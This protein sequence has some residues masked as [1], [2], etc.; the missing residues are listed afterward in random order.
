LRFPKALSLLAALA[1]A[2]SLSAATF[3]VPPDRDLV[4]RADAIVI[5]SP[6]TSYSRLNTAG[7]IET[8]TPFSV[9]EIV[10]GVDVP[11]VLDIVE[12]GGTYGDRTSVIGGVPR[13]VEGQRQ[14]LMVKRTAPDRWAVEELVLGK[15]T[16]AVDTRGRELLVRDSDEI[17]GWDSNLQPHH[18]PLRAAASFLQFVRDEAR[19]IP[20]RQNYFL[21]DPAPFRPAVSSTS[22]PSTIEP[23]ATFTATSYTMTV[24][25]SLG[26]RWNV[27]P[28]AV[29]FFTGT[30]TEPGAPGGGVTAVQ[31]AFAS[32]D[33]DCPSNVNYVYGGT[34]NGTHTSGIRAADGANTV[35]FE[36]D[37]S[38]LGIAPFTCSGSSYSG[39]LG[40]GG[41]TAA[42]GNNVVSGETFVTTQEGDVE[43]NRGIANCTLLFSNGD[44]NSAVTHEVGHTLGFRHSDQNRASNGACTADLECSNQ[45]IMRSFIPNGL[46]G[47]LQAWDQHA[48]QSVYPGGSCGTPG[49][50]AKRGDLDGSGR[51]DILWRDT[52]SGANT[53]WN[54]S[55]S[56]LLSAPAAPSMSTG[57]SLAGTGDFNADSRADLLWRNLN[58]GAAVI[59]LM[60]GQV[61]TGTINLP[62]IS[63]AYS[64]AGVG[65]FNGDG[66]ADILWRNTQ[67]A[68]TSIW[69][70]TPTGWS[71][72]GASLSA[73]PL[74]YRV[75]SVAD[76][77][78]DGKADIVWRNTNTGEVYTWLLN[79]GTVIGGSFLGTVSLSYALL[80]TG[81]FNGDGTF[82]LLWRNLSSGDTSVW[83]LSNGAFGGQGASLGTVPPPWNIVG[84]GDFNGDGRYDL[85][86]HNS[87]T[88]QNSIWFI[89]A[90]GRSG[91]VDLP[92]T[93]SSLT[94]VSPPLT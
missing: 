49:G 30:T 3:V 58:T 17:V 59:W 26:S 38:A 55:S 15:F 88:G 20:G 53:V 66:I 45:A 65:D 89:T 64:I 13:F 90:A 27:F 87:S 84:V 43:M 61:Q 92:S 63:T 42:S 5:G 39:T 71:G 81:D 79:G 70:M 28:N 32:W 93:N 35:L 40:V 57:Y 46:N 54:V 82:D 19:G 62:T 67:N 34:D 33:N 6:L 52:S 77:N 50:P 8:V 29:T 1:V 9:R 24:S 47:A 11:S 69:Y 60:N 21:T 25:G 73:V 16:F 23:T 51:S 74:A 76:F 10:G 31:T 86:W 75:I 72:T 80:G 56:G 83:F 41:I 2:S 14:L 12:P 78:A 36:R 94:A 37:L 68:D 22:I 91:G 44:W 18:E 4:H 48:V 85:L 7:G